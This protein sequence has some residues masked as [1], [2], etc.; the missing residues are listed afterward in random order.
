MNIFL[1]LAFVSLI[2]L[3]LLL[4]NMLLTRN[5]PMRRGAAHGEGSK[6]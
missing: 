1:L 4:V 5:H 6:K 3:A 2:G